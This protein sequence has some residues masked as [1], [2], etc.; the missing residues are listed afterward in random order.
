MSPGCASGPI[1]SLAF[2]FP[3]TSLLCPFHYQSPLPPLTLPPPSTPITPGARL[4]IHCFMFLCSCWHTMRGKLG[5]GVIHPVCKMACTVA[6][7]VPSPTLRRLQDGGGAP[8]GSR[9]GGKPAGTP[10][11]I[12]PLN[13][14]TLL[15]YVSYPRC[16]LACSLC[17]LAAA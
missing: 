10:T 2:I 8:A 13:L 17:L 11:C 6:C 1:S 3:L 7:V 14:G 9:G 4:H 15:P 12:T 5:I 16:F